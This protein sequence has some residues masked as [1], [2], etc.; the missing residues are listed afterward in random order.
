MCEEVGD[1]DLSVVVELVFLLA[2]AEDVDHL[3]GFMP[4][5]AAHPL[6]APQR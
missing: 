2:F 5:S 6:D 1:E 4:A 3:A